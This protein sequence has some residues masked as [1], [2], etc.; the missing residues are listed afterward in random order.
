MPTS[1]FDIEMRLRR[2]PSH[3]LN[4]R[5]EF[6]PRVC[7]GRPVIKGTRIPV[8]VIIGQLAE[9]ESWDAIKGY[10]E[11]TRADIQAALRFAG[12]SV[13]NSQITEPVP[14]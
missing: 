1:C 5:I 6:N 14:A 13:F 10:P 11:L 3:V 7:G 4:D 12:A 2:W 8:E 9:G